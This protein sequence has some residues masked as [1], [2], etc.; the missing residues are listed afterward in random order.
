M[1]TDWRSK[2]GKKTLESHLCI[3]IE[4]LEFLKFA[5]TFC[6]KEVTLR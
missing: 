4:G 3:K 5:E 6:Q 1:K 2:L